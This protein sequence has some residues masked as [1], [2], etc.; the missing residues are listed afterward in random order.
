MAKSHKPFME[1]EEIIDTFGTYQHPHTTRRKAITSAP[2]LL[3]SSAPPRATAS[4]LQLTC[5]SSARKHPLPLHKSSSSAPSWRPL[6]L[7]PVAPVKV[8]GATGTHAL[9]LHLSGATGFYF[10]FS[11]SFSNRI[12]S[13]FV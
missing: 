6:L 1:Q 13:V 10:S 3:I 9:L 11:I 8:P 7:I 5:S 2:I 12:F 4:A